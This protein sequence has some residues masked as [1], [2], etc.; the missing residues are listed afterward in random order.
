MLR[1]RRAQALCLLL[2]LTGAPA[3]AERFPS[4]ESLLAGWKD[5]MYTDHESSSVELTLSEPGGEP[6]RRSARIWFR[7]RGR[8]DSR[9]LMRFTAPADMRGTAFL[10]IRDSGAE[11]AADQWLFFPAYHKARRLSAHNRDEPFLDSDFSN[12]DVSFEY[13]RGFDFQVTG[14]RIWEGQ[15]VYVLEGRGRGT[16]DAAEAPYSREV[17]Y[18]RKSDRLNV[19]SEFYGKD[20]AL[21]KVLSVLEWKRYGTRWAADRIQIENASTHHRSTLVFSSRD[22]S[23]APAAKIFTLAELESGK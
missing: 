23:A 10:S 20:G 5:A 19:R 13:E 11:G 15:D 1:S 14:S 9:I 12:G 3:R 17:L 22:L 2:L 7:S 21:A 16:S 18:I 6:I 8:G 4:A